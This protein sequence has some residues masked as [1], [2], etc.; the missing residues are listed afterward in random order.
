MFSPDLNDFSF[1]LDSGYFCFFILF[2]STSLLLT[3]F[4]FWK[5]F[6]CSTHFLRFLLDFYVSVFFVSYEFSSLRFFGFLKIFFTF[7]DCMSLAKIWFFQLW[8]FPFVISFLSQM[9]WFLVFSFAVWSLLCCT[10]RSTSFFSFQDGILYKVNN[11]VSCKTEKS[12]LLHKFPLTR[13]KPFAILNML[14]GL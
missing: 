10:Y 8:I 5:K 7:F 2:W 14:G 1:F 12:S 6:R 13:Q 9:I 3:G 11:F 4:F